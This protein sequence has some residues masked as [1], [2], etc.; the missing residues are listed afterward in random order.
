MTQST[1][2]QGDI[3]ARDMGCTDLQQSSINHRRHM[4][5]GGVD[6]EYGLHRLSER[7]LRDESRNHREES[8]DLDI[9]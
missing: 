8:I 4:A 3:D 9:S 1:H 5:S 6:D 2:I 7:L